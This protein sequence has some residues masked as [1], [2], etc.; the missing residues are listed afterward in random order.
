VVP[1]AMRHTI[2]PW[3]T[4]PMGH[5]ASRCMY[6]NGAFCTCIGS[7]R[8]GVQPRQVEQKYLPLK[9]RPCSPGRKSGFPN[10]ALYSN[11]Q[12]AFV[13]LLLFFFRSWTH[14]ESLMTKLIRT[15]RPPDIA[16]RD[17]KVDNHKAGSTLT[18]IIQLHEYPHWF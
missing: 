11:F 14:D 4:P 5:Y 13:Y 1:N 15:R 6:L 8:S 12:V 7:P 10:N 18:I 3:H 16:S 2:V 17:A 9:T